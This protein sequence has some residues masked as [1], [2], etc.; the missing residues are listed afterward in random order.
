MSSKKKPHSKTHKT[1]PLENPYIASK[2]AELESF[3]VEK[4][5]L[6]DRLHNKALEAEGE[7]AGES[8]NNSKKAWA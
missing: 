8:S 1:D 5:K 2:L 7:T 3:Y 6:T 4:E